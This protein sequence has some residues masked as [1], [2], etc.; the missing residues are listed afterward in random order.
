MKL[1][2]LIVSVIFI[3]ALAQGNIH[4][5]KKK[6]RKVLKTSVQ[7]PSD[8]KNEP[9]KKAKTVDQKGNKSS[10]PHYPILF[11]HFHKSGG[12]S[13]CKL[14]SNYKLSPHSVLSANCQCHRVGKD[15]KSADP[16]KVSL[17]GIFSRYPDIKAC[18]IE[19]GNEWPTAE[20][21]IR[22]TRD[23]TGSS[24]T[25]LRDPWSRFKS[26]YERDIYAWRYEHKVKY[27]LLIC[28]IYYH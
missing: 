5:S 12:T 16:R 24:V 8:M 17:N 7:L 1:I 21:F 28:M 15:I 26:N 27:L 19:I 20:K 14:F 22:L 11:L 10:C 23:F 2:G 4:N 6:T 9:K 18:A 3:L 25:V 13:M